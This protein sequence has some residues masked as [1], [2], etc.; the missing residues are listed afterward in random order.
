M[1]VGGGPV[2]QGRNTRTEFPGQKPYDDMEPKPEMPRAGPGTTCA[3]RDGHEIHST[4]CV[5]VGEDAASPLLK[6]RPVL[7]I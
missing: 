7:N 2:C 3:R 5:D 6:F 1:G 4:P